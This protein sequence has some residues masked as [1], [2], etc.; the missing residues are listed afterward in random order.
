MRAR[1]DAIEVGLGPGRLEVTAY[2]VVDLPVGDPS[3]YKRST[4]NG[5]TLQ[6]TAP[7]DVIS[8]CHR[9]G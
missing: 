1:L 7:G 9:K 8:G 2:V 6:K 3:Y 4:Y 5:S